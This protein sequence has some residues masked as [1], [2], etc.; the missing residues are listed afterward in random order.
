MG[1][2]GVFGVIL[3]CACGADGAQCVGHCAPHARQRCRKTAAWSQ[4][5]YSFHFKLI[6]DV[7]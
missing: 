6:A 1:T 7:R 3:R 2:E 5:T 4:V